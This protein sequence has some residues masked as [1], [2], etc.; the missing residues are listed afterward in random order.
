METL[1]KRKIEIICDEPAKDNNYRCNQCG[2][3]I[4]S[5]KCCNANNCEIWIDDILQNKE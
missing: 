1:K 2:G 5:L 4:R 3:D